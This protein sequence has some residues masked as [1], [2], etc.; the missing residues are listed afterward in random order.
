MIRTLTR[1]AIIIALTALAA[2]STVDGM[3]KDLSKAGNA[4]SQS[5]S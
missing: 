3:G 2:C 5:A 4:I 1:S